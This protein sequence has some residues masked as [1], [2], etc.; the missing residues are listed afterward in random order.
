MSPYKS[1]AVLLERNPAV[2]SGWKAIAA[3]F[4]CNV[5]TARRYEQD[6]GLPVHR[7]P[8]KKGATVF[9]H[10]SELDAWFKSREKEQR[11][12][13]ALFRGSTASDLG[14]P[15]QNHSPLAEAALPP[16]ASLEE[17][18]AKLR[19]F[20]L[21]RRWI[22][23]ATALLI[24]SAAFF[25]KVVN[26]QGGAAATRAQLAASNAEPHAPNRE[27]EALFLRGRYFWN[28]R[29]ADGLARA[30]DAYTQAIVTDPSYAEAYA[31]LAESYD[32][33][34]QFGQADLGGSLMKAELAAD[35]AI[36]LNTNLAA[37]HRAKAFALFFWDWDI[38][39]SD[40]EFKKALALDP[41]SAQ[42]HQWYA[43]TLQ[44]RVE[45][46][47][48]LKQIDEAVRLDPTSAAVA[49]D[50]AYFHAE[51]GDFDAGVHA[52]KELEQTQPN[53]ATPALFLR[54]L[55][56][57]TGDYPGYIAQARR[58]ASITRSATDIALANEVAD[59]WA[60]DGRVGLLK[61]R[62]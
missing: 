44:A 60:R 19:S 31:G 22:F 5:R 26:H 52:L 39:G 2:L 53:L 10:P 57:A 56:F 48:C 46:D 38:A 27:A 54:Q 40:S 45:S 37:A 24:C 16:A 7:A 61:A 4:G 9:A 6:R 43:S 55:A 20:P 13:D 32:L 11:L 14:D 33:L 35:R 62:Y 42:T 3:Y 41:N 36:A 49:A 23:A 1:N 50:S 30:I 8:G 47:E 34:P 51:F 58:Y 12:D 28:L 17:R 18:H 25:W 29:T 59:G 15:P 21:R